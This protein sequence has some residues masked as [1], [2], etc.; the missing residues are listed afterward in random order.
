MD[1]EKLK[2][3]VRRP[4]ELLDRG[5]H[6]HAVLLSFRLDHR[7]P[8][9]KATA[10]RPLAI[11]RQAKRP[12]IHKATDPKGHWVKRPQTQISFKCFIIYFYRL[13]SWSKL[14]HCT[15]WDAKLKTPKPALR[16][17]NILPVPIIVGK[18]NW[19][20]SYVSYLH[21][22][23]GGVCPQAYHDNNR[24]G[25]LKLHFGCMRVRKYSNYIV[26]TNCMGERAGL[27]DR[28]SALG[29]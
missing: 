19:Q 24:W 10:D 26:R 4:V 14:S 29:K 9:H 15:I 17:I 3:I 18:C 13:F 2:I 1:L 11:K 20:C 6:G 25:K 8:G 23:V 7:N 28:S 22:K 12:P 16:V 27:E 21:M 5:S